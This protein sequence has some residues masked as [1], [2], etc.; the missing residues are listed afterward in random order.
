MNTLT[1][2]QSPRY[3]LVPGPVRRALYPLPRHLIRPSRTRLRAIQALIHPNQAHLAPV[4][5]RQ[6]LL[7]Q[8]LHATLT[9]I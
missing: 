3:Q 6:T 9:L 8:A 5:L 1:L 2:I 4:L 7:N